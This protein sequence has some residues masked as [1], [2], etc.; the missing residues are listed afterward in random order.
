MT[1]ADMIFQA[2]MMGAPVPAGTSERN[3]RKWISA[4]IQNPEK[5]AAGIARMD[6]LIANQPTE[7]ETARTPVEVPGRD[8]IPVAEPVGWYDECPCES[9]AWFQDCHGANE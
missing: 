4:A 7:E 1:V 3:L 8:C 6:M 9:G 2:R 5:R